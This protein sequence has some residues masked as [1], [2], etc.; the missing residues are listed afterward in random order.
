MRFEEKPDID[1]DGGKS[2]RVDCGE[3][4]AAICR[5]AAFGPNFALITRSTRLSGIRSTRPTGWLRGGHVQD[6]A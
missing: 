5:V 2:N 4:P 3:R 1:R 6:D